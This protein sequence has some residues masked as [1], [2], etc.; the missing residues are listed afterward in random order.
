[1][2]TSTSASLGFAALLLLAAAAPAH[3]QRFTF[4]RTFP[5]SQADALDIQTVRGKITVTGTDADRLIVR[6][7]VTVRVG[8]NVPA[9]AVDL[10]RTLAASPPVALQGSTVRLRGAADPD[11]R[12]A[13]TVSYEVQVPRL[14]RVTTV[15]QAGATSIEGVAAPLSVHTHSSAITLE[16]LG[17]TAGVA[18]GSGAVQVDGVAGELRVNTSSGSISARGVGGPLEVQTGSGSVDVAMTGTGDVRIQTHSSAIVAKGLRGGLNVSTESGHVRAGGAPGR[19]WMISTGSGAV[20][21]DLAPDAAVIVD[22]R[23]RSG[24]VTG[25]GVHATEPA[26]KRRI[27]GTINGGG[28]KMTVT[29]R[30]GS[31]LIRTGDRPPFN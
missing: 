18:T 21:L 26:T 25:E 19:P 6:G 24:S 15:S 22:A 1:M 16:A 14:T 13:A 31:I 2:P 8:V 7:T 29:S 23:S 9:D 27:V 4:E 10:A 3:A 12:R 28:P 30:S 17:S 20:D 5:S 11:T